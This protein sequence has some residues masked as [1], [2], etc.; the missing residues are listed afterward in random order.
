MIYK[1]HSFTIRQESRDGLATVS[2]G[3]ATTVAGQ[4]TP[5]N[6]TKVMEEYG[7]ETSR[8]HLLMADDSQASLMNVGALVSYG[9]RRFKIAAPPAIFDIGNAASH[10]SCV[11]DEIS[12]ETINA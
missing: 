6:Q 5:A 7:V 9:S 11:I 1:P 8:P 10:A 2:Y 12:P 3:A 4:I